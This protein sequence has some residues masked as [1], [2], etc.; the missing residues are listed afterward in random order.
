[1]KSK[2][3]AG[4]IRHIAQVDVAKPWIR[5]HRAQEQPCTVLGTKALS[6]KEDKSL[7]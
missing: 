3:N 7:V 1:M 6:S 2:G 5:G 4:T